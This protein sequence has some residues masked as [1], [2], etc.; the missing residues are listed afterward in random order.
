TVEVSVPQFVEDTG[1]GGATPTYKR[2]RVQYLVTLRG[3]PETGGGRR[4]ECYGSNAL[5]DIVDAGGL[6]F[7]TLL[8][9]EDTDPLPDNIRCATGTYKG[10]LGILRASWGQCN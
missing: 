1:F 2:F 10:S 6:N 3:I 4:N 8:R 7:W 5:W 9:W